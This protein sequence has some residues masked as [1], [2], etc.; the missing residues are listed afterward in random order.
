MTLGDPTFLFFVKK[1]Q[2]VFAHVD[3]LFNTLQ[4]S[5]ITG[6]QSQNILDTFLKDV[7]VISESITDQVN[8]R[9]THSEANS[10]SGEIKRK[11]GGQ[12]DEATFI[13]ACDTLMQKVQ[14]RFGNNKI[15]HA[16]RIIDQSHFNDYKTTFPTNLD[17]IICE[18]YPMIEKSSLLSELELLYSSIIFTRTQCSTPQK[19]I[20]F[21]SSIKIEKDLVEVSNVCKLYSPP[22]LQRH[23]LSVPS[24]RLRGLKTFQYD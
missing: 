13:E 8:D 21:I 16:L 18:E 20:H 23:S 19:I 5:A 1:F 22:L 17:Y 15:S 9:A 12:I 10:S 6:I 3:V 4:Q 14:D 24:V 2:L 7:Q 11:R